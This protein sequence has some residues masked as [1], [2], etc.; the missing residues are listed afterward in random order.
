MAMTG[1]VLVQEGV[2]IVFSY[3]PYVNRNALN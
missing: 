2:F 3:N 1:E